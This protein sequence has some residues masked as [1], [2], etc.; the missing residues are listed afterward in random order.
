ME[1]LD[2]ANRSSLWKVPVLGLSTWGSLGLNWS[3]VSLRVISIQA[4]IQATCFLVDPKI[5]HF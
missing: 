3:V 2:L 5:A 4:R 1:W